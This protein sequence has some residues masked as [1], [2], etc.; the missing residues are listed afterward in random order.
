[1]CNNGS[2][3]QTNT[4]NIYMY[5]V[6]RT[7]LFLIIFFLFLVFFVIVFLFYFKSWF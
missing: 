5:T 6:L 7:A 2:C 4:G 3:Y 1:M